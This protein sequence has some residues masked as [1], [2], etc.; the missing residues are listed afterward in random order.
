MTG[1]AALVLAH[2]PAFQDG[3]LRARSE[4]RV[5]AL[6]ELIRASAVPRFADPQHGGAGVPYLPRIPGSHGLV[7]GLAA[8]DGVERIAM[9]QY[10][11]GPVQGW[12]AWLQ[13]PASGFF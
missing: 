10:W 9:P 3:S 7:M 12:P 8:T 4:Q 6:F 11:P 1:L 5:H 13:P 2:H